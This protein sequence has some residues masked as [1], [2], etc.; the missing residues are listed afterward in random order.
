MGRYPVIASEGQVPLFVSIL[1][2][3]LVLHFVGF[4]ESL[5]LWGICLLLVLIFRNPLREIPA[6]PRA[7]V[8]PA[9]GE[10]ILLLMDRRPGPIPSAT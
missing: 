1:A 5:P 8:S 4:L 6:V 2:A 10:I 7:V 3:L 9:D